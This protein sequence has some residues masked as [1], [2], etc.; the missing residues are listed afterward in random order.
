MYFISAPFGNYINTKN[1]T[2]VTGSWTLAPRPGLVKQIATTL[3]YTPSGWRNNIGLRNKG[4][5]YALKHHRGYN[6]MSLAA[7]EK[8]DWLHLHSIVDEHTS[9]EINI[10]CPNLDKEVDQLY[11][12][13]DLWTQDSRKWCI[14]KISPQADEK[15]IDKLVE[16][17]YN[18]IH[19]SNSLDSP[20]GGLSGKV[21]KPFTMHIL[22]YIKDVHPQ[23]EV[24]AGGGVTSEQDAQDYFNAGA[25]HISLGTVCFTPWKL[26]GII[27]GQ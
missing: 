18:T 23:I 7:I 14:A 4:I 1:T 22:N 5:A 20:E 19:A 15:L 16:S 27:N 24:I 13:F 3:R 6:V 9:V 26:K 8:D 11:P 2:S 10:S 21:L 12:G 25:D 17:G